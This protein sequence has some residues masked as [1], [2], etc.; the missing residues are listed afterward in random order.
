MAS[1][2]RT[3]SISMFGEDYRELAELM[4]EEQYTTDV[5]ALALCECCGPI[6]VDYNGSRMG[7]FAEECDCADKEPVEQPLREYP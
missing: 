3:C 4:D 6:V 5:G 2:C 1:Y 7:A